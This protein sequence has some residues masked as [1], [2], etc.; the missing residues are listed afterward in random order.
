MEKSGFSSLNF[1]KSPRYFPCDHP[2]SG[3]SLP[4]QAGIV[5]SLFPAFSAPA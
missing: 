2:A 4:S 5:P 3:T 1:Q